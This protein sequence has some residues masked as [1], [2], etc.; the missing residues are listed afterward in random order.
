MI[1]WP[2]RGGLTRLLT[3]DSGKERAIKR[4]FLLM[5]N[6]ICENIRILPNLRRDARRRPRPSW[7]LWREDD[8]QLPQIFDEFIGLLQ[9][10]MNSVDFQSVSSGWE[11]I[12]T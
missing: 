4:S 7:R 9:N 3:A 2:D 11:K 1:A 12:I 8:W 10:E 5:L 6:A